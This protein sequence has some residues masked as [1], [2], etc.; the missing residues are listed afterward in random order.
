M[1]MENGLV[2]MFAG[3]RRFALAV[4]ALTLGACALAATAPAEASPTPS[5]TVSSSPKT[6]TTKSGLPVPS[7][8]S[9]RL[10][11][12]AG[13]L[14][15]QG[16]GAYADTYS[17]A[18]LDQAH[19]Q[20]ILY[21]TD[22]TRAA[23]LVQTAKL[24]HPGIATGLVR[25]VRS[26]YSEK[27]LDA[28]IVQ[29]LAGYG[30]PTTANLTI[31]S[32]S[33]ATDGSGIDLGVKPSAV[34]QVR[35]EM[36]ANVVAG[37]AIPVTVTAGFLVSPASATWRWNDSY[38]FVGGDVLL[39]NAYSG[40]GHSQ[41]TAG[42]AAENSAGRDYLLTADHCFVTG[43]K[44]WGDGDPYGDFTPTLNFGD[45][46]G[47]DI[48][49]YFLYDEALIDTGKYNGAGTVSL[50]ADTPAPTYYQ[51]T[52]DDLPAGMGQGV[53]QDGAHSYFTGH[54]VPC[55]AVVCLLDDYTPVQFPDGH[56]YSVD[57]VLTRS[58]GYIETAGDS[59][60]LVFDVTG[61][62]TRNALGML[63]G[64]YYN[65]QDGYNYMLYVRVTDV[66][67]YYHL[68]LNPNNY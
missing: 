20:V 44:V 53:C 68:H 29:I 40:R 26:A 36:A 66:L 49:G 61:A 9:L 65:N 41:C 2:T 23:A 7:A 33:P 3:A 43:S 14:I 17:S 45:Y 64:G 6:P 60:A 47:V 30:A 46:V 38:P 12:L 54:G 4:C 5:S 59:G 52:S 28:R 32:A 1:E 21:A 62:S 27:A 15:A 67:N 25:I 34:T 42:L 48:G 37:A 57:G 31:Y 55:N 13:A 16:R 56:W 10:T 11:D 24:A 8:A 50:E 22:T 18:V 63:E 19:D 51:V 39:G 35:T 58:T